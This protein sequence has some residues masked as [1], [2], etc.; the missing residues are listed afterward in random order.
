MESEATLRV[1]A[2][3]RTAEP[4]ARLTLEKFLP[5]RLN[6]LA[7]L[8]SLALSR[9]YAER[10]RIGVPEWRVLVTLGE[11]DSMTGKAVGAHSHMHKAKVSR[12]VAHL[13]KRR[14]VARRANRADRRESLLSLTSAG[15]M[16]STIANAK[17]STA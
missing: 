11:F 12:A 3:P 14:W 5:Y 1:S 2:P 8:S 13:E 6:V 16:G 7:S 15:S 17:R 9:I 10:Y 4:S